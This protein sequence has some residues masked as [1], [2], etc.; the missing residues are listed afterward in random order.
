MAKIAVS[1]QGF[2]SMI[3]IDIRKNF[4]HSPAF[5]SSTTVELTP[6]LTTQFSI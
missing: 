5:L 2:S 6:H 1:I 4:G 3:D